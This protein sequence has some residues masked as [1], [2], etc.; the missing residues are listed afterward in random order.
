MAG[1][2]SHNLGQSTLARSQPVPDNGPHC[3]RLCWCVTARC[4]YEPNF[5]QGNFARD[6]FPGA[7]NKLTE[8]SV[9]RFRLIDRITQLE[10]GQH[11][12]AVKRLHATE[13][14][15]EDHFPRFPIMPGVLM[16]ETMY[17]AAHWL[18]RKTEDF[19]HSMVVLKEARNVKF[20][21]FVKP[22][23]RLGRDGRN[24]EAGRQ[25]SRP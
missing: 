19:A 11:I 21:G 3:E 13:R 12:E 5:D 1:P 20:S 24:Q 4:G 23:Q 9:M 6:L 17:Q 7:G 2:V 14:Y 15:L 16:L 18:V 22:G 10:P 8:S 25:P